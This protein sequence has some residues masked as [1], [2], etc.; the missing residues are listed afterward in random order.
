MQISSAAFRGD[1]LSVDVAE[2]VQEMGRDHTFTKGSGVGVA[3]FPVA[4]ALELEQDVVHDPIDGNAA[5]S[6]VT[7]HKTG[8]T[9]KRFARG[10]TFIA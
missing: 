5:H 4:L 9:Q 6:L 10:S 1:E 3:E 7:G 8:G 2:L